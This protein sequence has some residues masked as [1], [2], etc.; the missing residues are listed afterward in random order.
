MA[1]FDQRGQQITYQYNAAGNINITQGLSPEQFQRLAGELAVT[2]SALTS[3]FKIL[4]QHQVPPEQTWPTPPGSSSLLVREG[5]AQRRERESGWLG[6]WHPPVGHPYA[7]ASAN[8]QHALGH[9]PWC[10]GGGL[11][12]MASARGAVPGS[13]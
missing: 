9:T 13:A 4:E 2:E 12:V 10:A 3:F 6:P 7:D 11:G 1:I 8:R 5:G